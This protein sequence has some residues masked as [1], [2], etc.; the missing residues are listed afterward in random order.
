MKEINVR[1]VPVSETSLML[2]MGD[3]IDVGQ[4]P[5]IGEV[6]R[7]IKNGFAEVCEV[8]ASYTSLLVQVHTRQ[9]GVEELGEKLIEMIRGSSFTVEAQCKLIELPV[10]YAP[11]VGPDLETVASACGLTIEELIAI[12]SGRDYTVCAVGFAPGFAFL[13]DV[14]QRIATPRHERPRSKVPAGSVGIADR[15]TAVYPLDTPG[16]WQLLG[17]CPVPVY[18]ARQT[19]MSPFEVGD[20]VRFVPVDRKTY[21][22]RGG[23]V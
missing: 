12:H 2:Y 11:E 5:F 9:A 16:G 1:W 14:D 8:T 3:E 7:R 4:A 21:L 6:A 17:R 15:Q 18:N 22:E 10:Y 19:P 23:C 20:R 13:A